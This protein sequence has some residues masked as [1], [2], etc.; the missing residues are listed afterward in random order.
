M[1][2]SVRKY[3]PKWWTHKLH[4]FYSF[5]KISD[6]VDN[7]Q[8]TTSPRTIAANLAKT[9]EALAFSKMPSLIPFSIAIWRF[10]CLLRPFSVPCRLSHVQI[11]MAFF[12]SR[13][14]TLPTWSPIFFRLSISDGLDVLHFLCLFLISDSFQHMAGSVPYAISKLQ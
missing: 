7:S 10:Y 13:I 3:K 12:I 4:A 11:S 5:R 8:K 9:W 14:F 2:P 6:L 1:S